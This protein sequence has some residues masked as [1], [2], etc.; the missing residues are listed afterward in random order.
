MITECDETVLRHP[1]SPYK[2]LCSSICCRFKRNHLGRDMDRSILGVG[3]DW[4]GGGSDGGIGSATGGVGA[5]VEY[6]LKLI[7]AHHVGAGSGDVG[8]VEDDKEDDD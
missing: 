7:N 6:E 8:G 5:V 3:G 1:L 2:L 4:V